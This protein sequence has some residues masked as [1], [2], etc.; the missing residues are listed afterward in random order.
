MKF[1]P[2]ILLCSL[3]QLP[4]LG[5][6]PAF[7]EKYREEV[8]NR[9]E[10]EIQKMEALDQEETHPDDSILFVG[11]SSIRLW[12]T[13]KEDMSPYHPIQRGF[14]GSKFSDLAIY[15]DRL[16]TPHKFQ[17]VVIFVA[18]DI[19]G[20][21][22]DKKP[23]EVAQFFKY[24][25]GK[26]L[27]HNPDA[28][29]FFIGIT[30][31]ASRAAVWKDSRAA[32]T[33]IREICL[34]TENTHFIGTESIYLDAEGNSKTELFRKDKLHLNE[35]GYQLWAAAIKS[36]LDSVFNQTGKVKN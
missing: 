7:V 25:H 6:Q 35:T 17:A 28:H 20:K 19:S 1:L 32:N 22:T 18:N 3:I 34:N 4:L 2:I 14:G 36:Q 16:I 11:S 23:E 10:K 5:E 12:S 13:I 27:D 26:I 15:A 30:P 8:V 31:T 29:V 9:W 21:E 24:F 33:A